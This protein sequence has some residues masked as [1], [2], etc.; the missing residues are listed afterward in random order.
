MRRYRAAVVRRWQP[1]RRDFLDLPVYMTVEQMAEYLQ[2]GKT[3]AYE[4][5][6][7][8]GFPSVRF[9][10]TIR[11]PREAFILYLSELRD[12]KRVG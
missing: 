5:V 2:I 1:E 10:R 3:S 4:L 9:G 12:Q 11:I 6:R 7:T 8:S